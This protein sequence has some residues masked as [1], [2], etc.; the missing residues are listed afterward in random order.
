MSLTSCLGCGKLVSPGPRCYECRR[1]WQQTY[2]AA[3]PVHHTLYQ[4][5][6]WKRLSAEVRAGATRCT[7]C[8]KPTTRLIAD[9]VIP[10]EVA[11]DRALDPTNVV[12]AC[13]GC[14]TRRGRN[15]KLPEARA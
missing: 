14:N 3:R 8:L 9:H 6:A 4:T 15:A 5:G 11:P 13:F 7:Y 12:P 2:D 1:R 10:V